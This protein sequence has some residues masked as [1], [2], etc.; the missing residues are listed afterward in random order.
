MKNKKHITY[1][2]SSIIIIGLVVV[3]VQSNYINN[4]QQDKTIEASNNLGSFSTPEVAYNECKAILFEV[5][6]A[7]N[8]NTKEQ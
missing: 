3:I 8:K 5:S 1:F 6:K 2:I 4:K 7:I